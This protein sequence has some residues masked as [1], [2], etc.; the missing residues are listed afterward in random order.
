[1]TATVNPESQTKKAL[2]L[3]TFAETMD[4]SESLAR[5]WMREKRIHTFRLGKFIMVPASEADRLIA[6]HTAENTPARMAA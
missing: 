6:E 2:R 5:Q 1:M 4:V 3:R